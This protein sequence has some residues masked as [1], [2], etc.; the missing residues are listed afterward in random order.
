MMEIKICLVMYWW[1]YVWRALLMCLMNFTQSF[2]NCPSVQVIMNVVWCM[3]VFYSASVY[4]VWYNRGTLLRH[5][6]II[7]ISHKTT[8]NPHRFTCDINCLYDHPYFRYYQHGQGPHNLVGRF[9]KNMVTPN[10]IKRL[11]LK[12]KVNKTLLS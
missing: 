2:P 12:G 10:G 11:V 8:A 3:Y 9:S 4:N 7:I 6:Y 5:I 1:G